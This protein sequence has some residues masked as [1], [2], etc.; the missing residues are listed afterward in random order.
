MR[1]SEK[2]SGRNI[3]FCLSEYRFTGKKHQHKQKMQAHLLLMSIPPP[4]KY[5]D[6]GDADDNETRSLCEAWYSHGLMLR[7]WFALYMRVVKILKTYIRA[8]R[9]MGRPLLNSL[10]FLIYIYRGADAAISP[11][12]AHFTLRDR[13]S[14]VFTSLRRALIAWRP[15]HHEKYR[16]VRLLWCISLASRIFC[17]VAVSLC[18]TP[19]HFSCHEPILLRLTNC[20]YISS[21][22]C[23]HAASIS[24]NT[25]FL[26]TEL[27]LL[28]LLF[29]MPTDASLT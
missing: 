14:Q 16:A 22:L 23:C 27:D 15:L 5:G 1:A 20:L 2:A 24:R 9:H 7:W 6:I 17:H 25:L 4:R 29:E 13:R 26:S 10:M 8:R 12:H 28:I 11:R 3:F 21:R 18:F 19:L